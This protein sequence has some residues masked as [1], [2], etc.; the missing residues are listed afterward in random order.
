MASLV[1]LLASLAPGLASALLLWGSSIHPA[2]SSIVGCVA[3]TAR[4]EL[5][6]DELWADARVLEPGYAAI[7][8]DL[9]A[10]EALRS[11]IRREWLPQFAVDGLGNWGHR[12]SPGEERVLGAGPRGE[13]RLVGSWTLLDRSRG[14]RGAEA[15]LR[16]EEARL[17]GEVYDISYRADLARL[18]VEAALAEEFRVL[19]EEQRAVLAALEWPVRRR[20]E[21]G[22]D[23]AWEGH[24]LEEALS[25]S[26]R[27][28]A[29]AEA[30]SAGTRAELAALVG[31]CA[32][33]APIRPLAG[34]PAGWG[35]ESPEVR[36]LRGMAAT[37][38][39]QAL[40]E[41]RRDDWQLQLL[42]TTGPTRSRAFADGPV[43]NEYLVGLSLSWTPDLAGIR[44]QNAAAERARA[45]SSRAAAESRRLQAERELGRLAAALEHGAV[46]EALLKDE[47]AQ[48]RRALEISIARWEAGVGRWTELIR[49]HEQVEQTRSLQIELAREL[50][51]AAIR[52]GE[53][54]GNLE[55]LPRSLGQGAIP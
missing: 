40:V 38:E 41:A 15:A 13:L 34:R 9:G 37:R 51:H 35:G 45:R 20:L 30:T 2:P 28:L 33:V 44:R 6:L 46:R 52:Y 31:R 5:T 21:A 50:A 55:E 24:L 17:R 3:D 49:A 47:L 39:A 10:E 32:S 42:G 7:E 27:R 26:A 22:L 43:M 1:P 48:T 8:S 16:S 54:R 53:L 12:L 25:R 11:A 19:R 4:A 18:Y 23:V 36:H 29:E 14:A